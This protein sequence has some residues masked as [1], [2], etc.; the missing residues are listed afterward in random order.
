M[1]L[2]LLLRELQFSGWIN[3]I[4]TLAWRR[5]IEH[6]LGGVLGIS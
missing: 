1:A 4:C 3:L 2:R 5:D 6:S